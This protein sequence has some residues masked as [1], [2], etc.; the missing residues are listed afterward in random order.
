MVLQVVHRLHADFVIETLRNY[1]L[2]Y[3]DR[4]ILD[5][6]HRE[7]NEFCTSHSLQ[8]VYVDLFDQ[9]RYNECVY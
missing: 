3:D 4:W 1:G 9:V 8:Q 6:I 7:V 5:K 2:G